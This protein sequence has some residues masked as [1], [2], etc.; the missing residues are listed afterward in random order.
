M[1]KGTTWVPAG[2]DYR[3]IDRVIDRS[4]E[5]VVRRPGS[6]MALADC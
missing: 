6:E 4:A 5:R 1:R 2:S 3:A